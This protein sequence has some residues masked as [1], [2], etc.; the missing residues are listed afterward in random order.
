LALR[1]NIRWSIA[2]FFV[3]FALAS[4]FSVTSSAL[5]YGMP[6]F[7]GVAVVAVIILVGVFFDILGLAAATA[8]ETPYRAMASE[9]VRGAREAIGIV[10]RADRV[11]NFCSD[12]VGDIC[13][14]VSG[15]AGATVAAGI[16][17]SAGLGGA[18]QAAAGVLV[19]GFISGLT[20]GGKA[21][22]KSLAI[23]HA[24]PIVLGMGKCLYMVE[25]RLG[26]RLFRPAGR[27]SRKRGTRR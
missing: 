4:G 15:A 21:L 16:A 11:S 18:W 9:R 24:V 17:A 7:L 12:V 19:S 3:S 1:P 22:G 26:V 23:R 10:R 20:V 8:E 13:G 5:L 27:H 2:I 6:W 14:I 25:R